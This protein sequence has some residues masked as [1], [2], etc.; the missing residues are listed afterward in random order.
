MVIDGFMEGSGLAPFPKNI[1]NYV[2]P[3]HKDNSIDI[4]YRII[5]SKFS[6]KIYVTNIDVNITGINQYFYSITSIG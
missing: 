3:I 2:C 1:Y 5:R 6:I 4:M